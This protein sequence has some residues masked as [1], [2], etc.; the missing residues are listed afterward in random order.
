MEGPVSIIAFGIALIIVGAI[1]LWGL[2][3]L[4]TILPISG[5]IASV[6]DFIIIPWFMIAMGVVC[7]VLGVYMIITEGEGQGRGL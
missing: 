2:E 1:L 5:I 4:A 7:I 3:G 6:N